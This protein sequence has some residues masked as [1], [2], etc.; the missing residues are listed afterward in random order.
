MKPIIPSHPDDYWT[1][2][3][4]AM[5][6]ESMSVVLAELRATR[7]INGGSLPAAATSIK[8]LEAQL[9]EAQQ[10]LHN[11][12]MRQYEIITTYERLK[13]SE[14]KLAQ[15]VET[16]ECRLAQNESFLASARKLITDQFCNVHHA[17]GL[18]PGYATSIHAR[19]LLAELGA[20]A[21]K[22][23]KAELARVRDE[24]KRHVA[25]NKIEV[26]SDG[27]LRVSEEDLEAGKFAATMQERTFPI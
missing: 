3:G 14:K 12:Q 17:D 2:H 24:L 4:R 5:K 1:A 9:T 22:A 25:K 16:G 18:L 23:T 27:T 13:E 6:G 8:A 15:S 11:E 7:A 21:L 10:K 19:L 20:D 26:E